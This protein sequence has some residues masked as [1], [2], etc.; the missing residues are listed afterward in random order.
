VVEQTLPNGLRVLA[1]HAGSVDLETVD[2]WVGA[3]TRRETAANNGA[4]HFLEHILFKGTPTRKPGE[5][6]AAIEDLGGTLDAATSW[7]WAHFYVTVGSSDAP[8]ALG[9]LSD[10]MQNAAIREADIEQ[11]RPV[12]L[13]EMARQAGS[14]EQ[15]LVQAFNRIEF[16]G[17]PYGRTIMGP[18][19]NVTNMKRQTLVDFFHANYVPSNVTVIMSGSLDP[20]DAIGMVQKAFGSWSSRPLSSDDVLPAA[21]PAGIVRRPLE[22]SVDHGY[23]VLG[24]RA[25]SVKELPDAYAMDVL[26]TLLGQGGNNRLENDL[27]RRDKIVSSITSNYL[28]QHDPGALTIQASFDP[29]NLDTVVKGILDEVDQLRTRPIRPSELAAAKH[30][31]LASYLFDVQTTSGRAGAL[32]FYA[33]IDSYKYD[34]NY[35]ANFE[36]V[37]P[38]QVQQVAR[39]YL[40]PSHYVLV[41]LLPRSNPVTA[42]LPRE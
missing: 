41:T 6:D 11:E 19:Q 9:I 2:V 4:A 39:K 33:V 8:A 35:I 30:A 23:L 36:A 22:G 32:G 18:E 13:S 26:L 28:T 29:G 24:F 7:D 34:T 27:L 14:P 20:Q 12:I 10:V 17:H 31:L 38:E 42:F 37:T 25:P 5:I 16:P 1:T 15:Q 3:G 40:D 21:A